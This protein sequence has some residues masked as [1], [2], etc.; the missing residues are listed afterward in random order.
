L[1]KDDFYNILTLNLI[2]ENRFSQLDLRHQ[3]L[4][5]SSNSSHPIIHTLK[6]TLFSSLDHELLRDKR[7]ILKKEF[8]FLPIFIFEAKFSH[9]FFNDYPDP[10]YR[11]CHGYPPIVP[12][13]IKSV[14]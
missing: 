7:L 3:R 12:F 8:R 2:R 11:Y 4:R 5:K 14:M 9:I 1:E 10:D 6:H 13:Q